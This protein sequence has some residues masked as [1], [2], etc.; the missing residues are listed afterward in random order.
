MMSLLT[1]LAMAILIIAYVLS[2]VAGVLLFRDPH[3]RRRYS[4]ACISVFSRLML[5]LLGVRVTATG[6]VPPGGSLVVA[7][8][9]SYLDILVLAAQRPCVFVTSHEV[10]DTPFL[11]LLSVL[12]GT[13][14]IERRRKG[15][16]IPAEIDTISAV[17]DA[18]LTVVIFPEGTSSNGEQVLPFKPTLLAAAGKAAVIPA[19]ISYDELNGAA[20]S[21]DNRDTLF[22]Y[23]DMTFLPHFLGVL[24]IDSCSVSVRFLPQAISSSRKEIA[25]RAR[26]EIV[27]CGVTLEQSISVNGAT[28]DMLSIHSPESI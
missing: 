7:N 8:H 23:G 1:A 26:A 4:S 13:L 16:N 28:S 24:C 17:I 9:V 18:G 20:V 15:C 6:P 12:G 25:R 5:R 11:G 21:A 2:A 14:F 27:A 10:R 19:A 22:W 3:L